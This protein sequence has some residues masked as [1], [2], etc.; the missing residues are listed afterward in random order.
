MAKRLDTNGFIEQAKKVHGGRYDYSKV[1]YI[2]NHTNVTIGCPVHGYINIT[3]QNHLRGCGCGK[4]SVLLKKQNKPLSN[5]EFIYKAKKVHGDKYDYSKVE[6]VDA[7]T[8]VIIGCPV[9]GDFKQKP[10]E[11]LRGRGCKKCGWK[12][13]DTSS[14]ITKAM[15]VHGNRYDYSKVEYKNSSTSVPIICPKHG[16]FWQKPNDHLNGHGCPTC[17]E[18]K[19]EKEIEE[20]LMA[21][22]IK[23]EKQK[24]FEWLGRL[25]ID[26]YLP[27]YNV[28][29][30]CQGGQHF[31]ETS[32]FNHDNFH[33]RIERDKRK[34]KLCEENGVNIFY[35]S[36]LNIDYPYIVYED[37]NNML[38]KIVDGKKV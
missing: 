3:P 15:L 25:T 26:F 29:I 8:D 12:Q 23:F 38:K 4:C 18:S 19:L 6:Y 30:E 14:F 36:N 20:H 33:D 37:K 35:F 2:N 27:D 16:E 32:W 5:D 1:E 28:G 13:D 22:N 21:T 31:L 10:G 24:K 7:H 11:H 17:N 9:H 34:R